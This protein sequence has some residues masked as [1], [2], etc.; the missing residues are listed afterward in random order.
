M[1]LLFLFFSFLFSIT[2]CRAPVVSK[3]SQGLLPWLTQGRKH[4]PVLLSVIYCQDGPNTLMVSQTSSSDC[5]LVPTGQNQGR[6]CVLWTSSNMQAD[7]L[8]L[9]PRDGPLVPRCLLFRSSPHCQPAN[10]ECQRPSNTTDTLL[11]EALPLTHTHIHTHSSCP[12]RTSADSSAPPSGQTHTDTSSQ[13][14]R[15]YTDIPPPHLRS[16][17]SRTGRTMSTIRPPQLRR[18]IFNRRRSLWSLF[19]P[20]DTSP[21]YNFTGMNPF[22]RRGEL[23]TSD[24][25]IFLACVSYQRFSKTMLGHPA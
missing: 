15:P 23:H 6:S 24:L 12:A 17:I 22:N 7:A 20:T 5:I 21:R 8:I 10:L 1:S 14:T 13:H 25:L 3:V 16:P 4:N 18:P 19:L 2:F 11:L 9:D